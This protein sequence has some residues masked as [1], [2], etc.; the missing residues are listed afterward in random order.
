MLP[1]TTH[2]Q[3]QAAR[4]GASASSAGA[5]AD[6]AADPAADR[7]AHPAA[8]PSI[9]P[10]APAAG[11]AQPGAQPAPRPGEKRAQAVRMPGPVRV[12]L[13]GAGF[14][15]DFHL[16]VLRELPGVQALALV[17]TD[18]ERARALAEKH[19][20]PHV[21]DELSRLPELGIEVAHVLVPPDLHAKL[22]QQLLELGIGVFVE[23]PFVLSSAEARLLSALAARNGLPLGVNHNNIFHTSF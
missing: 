8:Q 9:G 23:K 22:V 17:D 16:D 1:E 15:A 6:R 11:P 10:R 13:I 14:I 19:G 21:L 2:D 7:A 3:R 18:V 12:A 5:S 4:A 20:V